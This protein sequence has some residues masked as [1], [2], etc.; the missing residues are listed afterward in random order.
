MRK[1]RK[2]HGEIAVVGSN[3]AGKSSVL[4]IIAGLDKPNNGDAS[5]RSPS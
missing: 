3:G 1:V 4:R 5:T 2:A